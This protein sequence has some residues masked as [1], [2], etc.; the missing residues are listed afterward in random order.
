MLHAIHWK[1]FKKITYF[2]Y[3]VKQ[4]MICITF[5]KRKNNLH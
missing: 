2:M 3:Y 4:D 1:Q 5:Q